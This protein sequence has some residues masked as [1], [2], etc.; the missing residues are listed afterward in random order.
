MCTHTH[1]HTHA[2]L[3]EPVSG[4]PWTLP[5]CSP[6]KQ[7]SVVWTCAVW[8]KC[9]KIYKTAVECANLNTI[10]CRRA[11]IRYISISNS[12][13]SKKA[14]RATRCIKSDIPMTFNA[15]QMKNTSAGA[16]PHWGTSKWVWVKTNYN[17]WI[18][19]SV[20]SPHTVWLLFN[21]PLTFCTLLLIHGTKAGREKS[22]QR[23][24]DELFSEVPCCRKGKVLHKSYTW[25]GRKI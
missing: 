18:H 24:V 16:P 19:F 12:I 5:T 4:R 2:P 23:Q 14:C 15:L 22:G 1:T 20:F 13:L 21:S 11:F 3:C 10:S 6:K 17:E 25:R 7:T 9:I 8:W